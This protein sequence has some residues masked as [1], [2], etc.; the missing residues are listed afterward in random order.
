MEGISPLILMVA[1]FLIFWPLAPLAARL[2]AWSRAIIAL[3][4]SLLFLYLGL[5][6]G[7]PVPVALGVAAVA[8]TIV[9]V[10]QAWQSGRS[11]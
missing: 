6:D 10:V 5:A 7:R 1:V 3:P 4:G 11:G 8:P 2:P 9:L